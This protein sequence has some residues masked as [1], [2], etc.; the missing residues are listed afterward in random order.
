MRPP[1]GQANRVIFSLGDAP[2]HCAGGGQSTLA[3]SGH[4]TPAEDPGD[5]RMN[6]I[7][8]VPAWIG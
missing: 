5:D 1:T 7:L 6:R 8:P 3:H 4:H 2:E